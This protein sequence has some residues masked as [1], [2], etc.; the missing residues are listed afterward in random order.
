M[1]YWAICSTIR[2]EGK[3]PEN[4]GKALC[5]WQMMPFG[6]LVSSNPQKVG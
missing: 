6:D 2:R 3:S 5:F 4:Q 1:V